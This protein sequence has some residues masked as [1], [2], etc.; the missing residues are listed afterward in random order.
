MPAPKS[1]RICFLTYRGNPSCG[2]QGIYTRHLTRALAEMGHRVEVWS[3][4]PYPELDDGVTLRQI[5]GLDLWRDAP[6]LRSPAWRELRDPSNAYEWLRTITGVF[7]EPLAF[8]R[9]VAR[10]LPEIA[11]RFDAVHDNQCI[12]AGLLKIQR[13]VPV[14]ATIH[15]PITVD[16]DI[17][18]ETESDGLK[19]WGIERW[20]AFIR[21]QRRVAPRL[22]RI[23]TVSQASAEGIARD[24]AIPL[25]R[26]A[27][28]PN[29]VDLDRFRPLHG[30]E[31]IP[32]R[33]VSTISS[34]APLKGLPVLLEAVALVKRKQP[35]V[36]LTI[37]G[38]DGHAST[39]AR[40]RDLGLRDT[41]VFT[42]R[43]SEHEMVEEYARANLA[44]VPSLYEGF[45]LP[46]IEAMACG[47]P[48]V[49]SDAG[50]LPEVIG[51]RGEAGELVPAG[52][53]E[54]LAD[55]IT[56][57]LAAPQ[58][59]ARM[60]LQGRERAATRFA[61]KAAAETVTDIYREEIERRASC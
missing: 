46:A 28:V 60:G 5:P 19:R 2:G 23:V 48:V 20:Y 9:R 44:V 49:S 7:A 39:Q 35:N 17:A 18:L 51:P 40:I 55:A 22:N 10:A 31:P 57:L 59:M 56:D 47:V 24:F 32:N 21:E 54:A 37:I 25:D 29:G 15:H 52:N 27:I 16:R 61:W 12:G 38:R 41:V 3:G 8:S 53:S 4:P 13:R 1:L 42:G 30:T 6:P 36:T 43:L 34:N 58:K 33:I 11:E 14:V 26:M 45:G 50:A